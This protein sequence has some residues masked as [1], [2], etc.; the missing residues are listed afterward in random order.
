M[1]RSYNRSEN[2]LKMWPLHKSTS[3]SLFFLASFKEL[4]SLSREGSGIG[5]ILGSKTK[6]LQDNEKEY[7]LIFQKKK[8]ISAIMQTCPIWQ[9]FGSSLGRPSFQI[10]PS[11][12][13]S[14]KLLGNSRQG[15]NKNKGFEARKNLPFKIR[16]ASTQKVCYV[17]YRLTISMTQQSLSI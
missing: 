11:S 12:K 3:S 6:I 16:L 14:P 10:L 7:H 1:K 8:K 15:K 4:I 17:N 9:S 2:E 5:S 13:S